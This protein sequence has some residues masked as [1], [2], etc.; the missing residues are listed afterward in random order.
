MEHDLLHVGKSGLQKPRRMPGI[1]GTDCP[2]IGAE[3]LLNESG[4]NGLIVSWREREREREREGGKKK[5]GSQS[6]VCPSIISG[7]AILSQQ[8][9]T[10][11]KLSQEFLARQ[12]APE[13]RSTKSKLQALEDS[14]TSH[15]FVCVS[16]LQIC[17]CAPLWWM[18]KP[19]K[20]KT[21]V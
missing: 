17:F 14:P 15:F 19:N 9:L 13:G 8:G 3:N 21:W 10:K 11:P 6:R 20:P 16:V 5:G 2:A 1:Q 4:L 12:G 18:S 7:E